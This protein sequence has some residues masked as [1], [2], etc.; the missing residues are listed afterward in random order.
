M[1]PWVSMLSQGLRSSRNVKFDTWHVLFRSPMDFSEEIQE[2]IEEASLW[3][4]LVA[5]HVLWCMQKDICIIVFAT[6]YIDSFTA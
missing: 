2:E 6:M 5:G 3:V 1:K 4:G